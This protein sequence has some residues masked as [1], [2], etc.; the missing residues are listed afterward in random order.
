VAEARTFPS[1]F[2]PM[3]SGP[4]AVITFSGVPIFSIVASSILSVRQCHQRLS[5][6]QRS[7]TTIYSSTTFLSGHVPNL[8]TCELVLRRRTIGPASSLQTVDRSPCHLDQQW[9]LGPRLEPWQQQL[10]SIRKYV[11]VFCA[12]GV[13]SVVS[14]FT[15]SHPSGTLKL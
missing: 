1:T 2:S 13:L 8:Q 14:G 6:Q 10:V 5:Y 7:K 3:T 4:N 12:T 9:T 15:S 11:A